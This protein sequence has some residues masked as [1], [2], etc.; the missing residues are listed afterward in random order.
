MRKL[1]I[2]ALKSFLIYA[3][4]LLIFIPPAA[5]AEKVVLQ[6]AW[7]HQFQFAGY[8]AAL[9]QGYYADAGYEVEIRSRARPDG[10]LY[11]VIREVEEGRADFG[12]GS[13]NILVAQDKGASLSLLAPVFQQSAVA[14]Y[15]K[16]STQL[17]SPAD[18]TRLKVAIS[19]GGLARA[20]FLAMLQ[21]EDIDPADINMINSRGGILGLAKGLA[22]AVIGYVIEADWLAKE[23]GLS[24]TSLRP[25]AYGVDFYGDSLYHPPGPGHS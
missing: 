14:L 13:G 17:N 15:A 21:G 7:D 10:S 1:G 19:S 16:K 5:A 22:D 2:R 18:L 4:S 9:W 25:V 20:E 3:L 8:Y 23:L 12:I 11:N 6:L 24:L